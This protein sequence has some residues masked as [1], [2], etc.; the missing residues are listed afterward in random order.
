MAENKK[1]F[2]LHLDSLDILDNMDDEQA[3]RFI[4]IIRQFKKTGTLPELDFGMSMAITPFINQFKRDEEK[5][6]NIIERNRGNGL[7]GGRPKNPTEPKKP[8]GLFTNPT[9]PKKADNDNDN[10]SDN[11]N[12]KD[13]V[14]KGV[15][16]TPAHP[17]FLKFVSWIKLNAAKV[18][19]MKEPF[20][21]KQFFQLKKDFSTEQIKQLLQSMH[22]YQPLLKKNINANLTFRNWAKNEFNQPETKKAVGEHDWEKAL[23]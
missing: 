14:D 16:P 5:Y 9:E 6:Q 21:E 19:M 18:S 3:G 20:T 4:K 17:D 15:P 2:I 13:K 12:E 7:A 8:T 10:D 23:L 22:N 11:D 1:S